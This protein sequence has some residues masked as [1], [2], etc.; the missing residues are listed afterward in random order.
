MRVL[1]SPPECGPMPSHQRSIQRWTR[2]ACPYP[3]R[4]QR[5]GRMSLTI[6]RS[7][8]APHAR[9]HG[10]R[11]SPRPWSVIKSLYICTNRQRH[12]GPLVTSRDHGLH[13]VCL[14]IGVQRL[15]PRHRARGR[16]LSWILGAAT[17]SCQRVMSPPPVFRHALCHA[18]SK[19]LSMELAACQHVRYRPLYRCM[20]SGNRLSFGSTDLPQPSVL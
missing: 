2:D 8:T 10:V 7:G 5:K 6:G 14:L 19:S 15:R 11:G 1:L 13:C 20:S 4:G 17:P 3:S 18:N 16:A 9:L 12:R